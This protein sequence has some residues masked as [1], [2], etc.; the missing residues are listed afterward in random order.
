MPRGLLIFA[1]CLPLAV[2]MGF[3]L[4]DPMVESNRWIVGAA[5]GS[6]LIPIILALHQRALIWLTGAFVNVYF[7]PGQPRMWMLVSILS[8]IIILLSRPLRKVKFKPVWDRPTLFFLT[9]FIAA[10]VLAALRSGG[11]GFRIFGSSVYGGRKYVALIA[12]FVGF[13]ALTFQ[14][15]SRKYAQK[16]LVVWA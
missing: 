9:L 11:I 10:V 13:M 3:M 1:L 5:L 6:L 4:A 7:L 8:F 16:D 2:L 15:L 14:P 12:S